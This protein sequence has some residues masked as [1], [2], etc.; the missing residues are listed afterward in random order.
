MQQ[1]RE[2]LD[3]RRSTREPVADLE[4][5][6]KRMHKMFAAA[7]AEAF[8]EELARFDIDAPVVVIDGVPHRQVLRC[9]ETYFASSGPV[10][11][12]RSLY[13]TR[14]PGDRAVC[15]LELR[16]GM[17]DGRWSPLAAQQAA[18]AVAH[19]TPQEAED[20][21]ARLGNMTPSKS[22]LDRLPKALNE[23]WERARPLFEAIVRSEE[24]VQ[25]EA[26]AVGVS[27]DGVLVPM[28][29]GAREAKREAAA[30]AGRQTKGPTGYQEAACATLSFYDKWG[31]LLST[32][33]MGR[34]PEKTKATLKEMLRQELA[35][36]L[37]Q[38]PDLTVMKLADGAKDN[39]R[40]LRE[41]PKGIEVL[42]FYHAAEHLS[43]ALEAAYGE[44]SAKSKAQF[45]KLRH[46][47][48]HDDDGIAKVIRSLVHLRRQHPRSKKIVTEL[49]YFRR[50]RRRMRYAKLAARNLPIGS[51]IVE[52]AC[53]TLTSRHK[54]SGMRWR[55][56]GGQAIFTLRSLVQ[57]D[58]FDSAW[59]LLATSYKRKVEV[60]ENVIPLN[61]RR[62]SR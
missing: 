27:I 34:M 47:L 12:E 15:P 13:S 37:G 29:D 16:A 19:L 10:R 43:G 17:I 56:Q 50:N 51:G 26:V 45:E 8:G 22:S 55:H 33:R 31:E 60:P 23:V 21:F 57:S 24:T 52:A 41:L 62:V 49:K 7:E 5:F 48:R 35:H 14:Q 54:R 58:R 3:E 42:D 40:Y 6:E 20:L 30:A 36:V 39:W 53:K 59:R 18:F 2:F 4:A 9:P 28:K 46:V 32:I 11:V 1:L 38:R 61:M 25:E 44:G